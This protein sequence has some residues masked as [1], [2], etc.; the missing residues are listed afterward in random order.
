MNKATHSQTKLYTYC[1]H[2]QCT[3]LLKLCTVP[4]GRWFTRHWILLS[5]AFS[6][7]T[8]FHVSSTR[9][10]TQTCSHKHAHTHTHTHTHRPL[11]NVPFMRG[12]GNCGPAV[13]NCS[14]HAMSLPCPQSTNDSHTHIVYTHSLTHTYTHTYTH[15]HIHVEMYKCTRKHICTR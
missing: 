11:G 5:N 15:A 7:L 6:W 2:T 8:R 3:V 10:H 9:T 14:G 1:T 13:W 4:V 12:E